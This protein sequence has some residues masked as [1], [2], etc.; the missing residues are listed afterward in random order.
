MSA[1]PHPPPDRRQVLASGVLLALTLRPVAAQGALATAP[2]PELAAAI[3]QWAGAVTPRDGRVGLQIAP[4][5]E[6]GN[7]VPVGITVDSPMTEADHVR[8][9]VLF[10]E[11]NPQRDVVRFTLSPMNGRAEVATRI[12][13]STSQALVAL[14]RLSDGSVWQQ[15][16]DVVVTLAACI[17]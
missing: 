8:E 7:A 6:N 14:A 2:S 4:L 12:R 13:L 1:R 15:R 16:A 10:N 9:I 5:V 17:E 3:A 11:R